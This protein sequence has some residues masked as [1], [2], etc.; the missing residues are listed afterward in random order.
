MESVKTVSEMY[1]P[2]SGTIVE[3]NEDLNDNPEVVNESPY[4]KAWIIVMEPSDSS[5]VDKLMTAE[6][7]AEMTKED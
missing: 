1:A 5:E 2:I 6:Q 4:D 7:Y 3:I